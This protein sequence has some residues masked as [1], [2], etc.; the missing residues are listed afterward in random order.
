MV[1]VWLLLMLIS[2]P[3]Q[4]SVKYTAT[5]YSTEEVC[6]EARRGYIGAFEAKPREY[7]DRV[8]TEAFCIPFE[9]Y[10]IMGMQSPMGA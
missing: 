5:I 10:P 7:K 4:P 3:N 6:L 2:V 8:K 9:S 1:K